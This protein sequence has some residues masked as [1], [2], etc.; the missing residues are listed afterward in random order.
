MRVRGSPQPP[1]PGRTAGGHIDEV[2]RWLAVTQVLQARY[3]RTLEHTLPHIGDPLVEDWGEGLVVSAREHEKT[4]PALRRAFGIDPEPLAPALPVTAAGIVHAS[5]TQLA[6]QLQGRL[7]SGPGSRAWRGMRSVL[8]CNLDAMSA[9]AVVQQLGLALGRPEVVD[10]AF[11][12]VTRK[13]EQQLLLQ[14]LY[15]EYA[16]GAVLGVGDL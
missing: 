12:V 1:G 4:L 5:A 8:L 9:F 13:S 3:R 16:A 15:L 14:E 7:A 11:P 6:A 10:I 2:R